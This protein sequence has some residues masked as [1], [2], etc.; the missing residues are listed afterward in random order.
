[1]ETLVEEMVFIT[2][3]VQ[4]C[5][6]TFAVT[7]GFNELR[8]RDGKDFYCPNGHSLIKTISDAQ[9]IKDLRKSLERAESNAKY[10]RGEAEAMARSRNAT[11][12]QL[13][14]IKRRIANGV[15]PCCNRSFEDLHAH[16]TSEHP[17]YLGESQTEK[18][19]AGK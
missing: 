10:F 12:G 15:C 16:M 6:V 18:E 1:M 14:K 19:E 4:G 8:K 11:K 2:C 17:K 5:G 7:D 9:T 3:P 13:T